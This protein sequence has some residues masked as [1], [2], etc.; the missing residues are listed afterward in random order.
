LSSAAVVIDVQNGDIIALASAPG[1][2]PNNFVFGIKSGVWNAL[3]N[4]EYLLRGLRLQQV[5]LDRVRV[6]GVS[7]RVPEGELSA[8][9]RRRAADD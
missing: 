7:N 1:F 8:P 6:P 3:L 4:D 5:A 2:D 9:L